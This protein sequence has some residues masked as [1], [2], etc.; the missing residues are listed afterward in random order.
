MNPSAPVIAHLDRPRAPAVGGDSRE[1]SGKTPP[2]VR[3]GCGN[4]GPPWGARTMHRYIHAHA[5]F[6]LA[7]TLGA[8]LVVAAGPRG[9]PGASWRW[10]RDGCVPRCGDRAGGAGR[11]VLARRREAVW[12]NRA[13]T[14]RGAELRQIAIGPP[15]AP[16]P[17]APG[18]FV[19][20]HARPQYRAH[21]IPGRRA[22]V[23]RHALR[24]HSGGAPACC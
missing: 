20:L 5:L 6:C 12:R 24:Q 19:T 16:S 21:A 11:V 7:D 14:T 10:G 3:R 4:L 22:A 2:G 18:S 23:L 1:R 13:D 17:G 9:T 8:A 15:T